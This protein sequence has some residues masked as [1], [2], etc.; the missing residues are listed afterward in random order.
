[1][2]YNAL[3]RKG[4]LAS[5]AKTEEDEQD[6]MESVV[7]MHNAMNEKSWQKVLQWEAATNPQEK[8]ARLLKFQGRPSDLSPKAWF[9]H[10]LLGHPLPFDRHDWTVIRHDGTTARYVL[11][12]YYDDSPSEEETAKKS[13]LVDVRP[14][15][16]S[17][18]SLWHRCATMPT[19]RHLSHSTDFEPLP[20]RPTH[21]MQTQ[22]QE[23]VKVWQSI[24]ADVAA[25]RGQVNGSSEATSKPDMDLTEAKAKEL[26]KVFDKAWTD[27]KEV[28]NALDA[29]ESELECAQA[30]MSFTMC[31]AQ[32]ACPLQHK[33]L[34]EALQN[35]D[36]HAIDPA[37][38]RV[39]DCVSLQTQLHEAAKQ[40]YPHIF[41]S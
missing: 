31:M 6:M 28:R 19:A 41:K 13:L 32:L 15:L 39:S 36:D 3:A 38:E 5:A 21:D 26:S 14:A 1:M 29:C 11:D 2:F 33:T 20:L 8:S 23:S 25:T 34:V 18:V 10:Y 4:K 22:V 16:D 37:L 12:Y 27:C 30:S 7:A 24:Q 35:D 40:K 9:K 17:P